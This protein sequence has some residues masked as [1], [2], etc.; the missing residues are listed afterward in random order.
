M[1]IQKLKTYASKHKMKVALGT[2]MAAALI[3]GAS[4][5]TYAYFTSHVTA[6]TNLT[7]NK[8]TV[9]L[10]EVPNSNWKYLGN[11]TDISND[12]LS[13]KY[14]DISLNGISTEPD[15]TYSGRVINPNLENSEHK[16]I[17]EYINNHTEKVAFSS[18][19]FSN[20]VPG[21]VFRKT[22]DIQYT[23]SN[24]AEISLK[25]NWGDKASNPNEDW[26]KFNNSFN[27]IVEYRILKND[28]NKTVLSGPVN[29]FSNYASSPKISNYTDF[30]SK[31]Y[32]FK[33]TNSKPVLVKKDQTI[34]L[35]VTV[36][37][38]N[39]DY[40][41]GEQDKLPSSIKSVGTD[42][43]T[44]TVQNHLESK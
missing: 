34:E 36:K 1:D 24:D 39:A 44:L 14:E 5:G 26:T 43:F 41:V 8:G 31:G 10:G 40:T 13:D 12:N 32:K 15:A 27:Y 7:L 28:K 22:Y 33:D 25:L 29:L 6:K 9:T 11:S 30:I 38:K 23:G 42:G 3:A 4:A 20:I 37:L 17:N 2:T 16:N 35:A 18:A 19:S 21:D